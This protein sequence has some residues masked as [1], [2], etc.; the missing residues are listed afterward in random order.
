MRGLVPWWGRIGVKLVLARLPAGYEVW[1]RLNLFVHGAM[2]QSDYALR[3]FRQ[4]FAHSGLEA[5]R[6]FVALELGPGDSLSSALV[7]AAYG[8]EHTYLVDAGAY[9]SM[10]ISVYREAARQLRAGGLAVPE[11]EACTNMADLLRVCRATYGTEGLASL[12]QIPTASVDFIWS[13]AV[14]EHVRRAEFLDFARQCHRV[15]RPCG[16]CSHQIDLKDHLGGGLNNL[17][18]A[19]RW[20]EAQWMARSGFYTNRMRKSE[21]LQAFERAGFAVEVG[22][23]SHWNRVPIS[24]SAL[25]PEFRE[26]ATDELLVKGFKVVLRP[27]GRELPVTARLSARE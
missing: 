18:I 15:L 7:A 2:L 12:R 23:L 26:L 4:H 14:L 25:A 6:P 13:H 27:K 3:V 20:W 11:I 17:R 24:R 16:V 5:G 19:S 22:A 8:A 1:R 9:A 21:I 10:D